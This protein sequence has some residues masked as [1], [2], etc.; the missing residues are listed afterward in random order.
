[1]NCIKMTSKT[2][3]IPSCFIKCFYIKKL[4]LKQRYIFKFLNAWGNIRWIIPRNIKR[5][6]GGVKS[7]VQK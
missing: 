5:K 3:S 6:K 2:F 7:V 1:M 4:F